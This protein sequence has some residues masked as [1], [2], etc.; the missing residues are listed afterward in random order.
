MRFDS[1]V[2][3][4]D[5]FFLAL[6]E[7]A[8]DAM[9]IV[10]TAGTIVLVNAQTEQ[11]FGY[12]RGE[13]LGQPIEMLLPQRFRAE[14]PNFR[15]TCVADPH[16]RQSKTG[17]N[18]YGLRKHGE[19]FAIEI[20][21]S[22]LE[23][24]REMFVNN[25]IR[26]V[27]ERKQVERTP[28]DQTLE[29]EQARQAK[30][31]TA[32]LERELFE[33]TQAASALRHERDR[34]LQYLDTAAGILLA[35][36]LDGRI[37]LINRKGCAILGWTEGELHG[38]NWIEMCLPT[39][40]QDA[41]RIG[42]QNQLHGDDTAIES[43]VLTR[44]G[45]ER[46]IEWRNTTLRDD[47]GQVIGTFSSG[48]DITERRQ[49]E[50]AHQRSE[51][52]YRALF[53]YAPDGIV[54]ADRESYYIDANASMCRMLGYSREEFIGLHASDIV[55]P[56]E[57]PQI[58][59]ALHTITTTADYHREWQ[60]RRK[61][62]SM[63]AADVIST[64]LPDGN[65]LAMIRDVTERNQSVDAVR[66]AEERMRFALQH[67]N[68]GIWDMDYATGVLRWS[69]TI[70]V[71]YCVPPG[72]FAGTFEAFVARI[73][74]DDRASMLDTVGAA[75][76]TGRDFTVEH[77][78][79]C[80]D[81]SVRWVSGA[82]RTLLGPHGE[83]VRGVGITQDITERKLAE[84]ILRQSEAR[85]AAILDSVLD[86]IVTMDVNGN[87]IEFNAAAERTFGYSKEAAMGRNLAE[88]IIPPSCRE[89]HSAGLARYLATGEGPLLGTLI[90]VTAIRS[91]GA[92]VPVELAIS[93]IRS[94][95]APM[96]TGVL[97]DISAR[98]H[99]DETRARL[100]AIVD[101]SDDAIFSMAVDGTI[102]TW[103][104]GAER[105]Y[106]YTADDAIGRNR[107]LLVPAGKSGEL[108]PIMDRVGRGEAGELLETQRQRKDGSIVEISLTISP[109]TD[110]TGQVTGVCTI[111]RD[112]TNRKRAEIELAHL[113]DEIQRQRLR[114]FKA[115]MRT[116]QDIVNNLL[117]NLQLAHLEGESQG[118]GDIQI[119]VERV[120]QETA[121]KLKTLG[122]LE[123]VREKEMAVGLGIDYPGAP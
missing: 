56:S 43:P 116:V 51:R 19:E 53:E 2:A 73:H 110:R 108:L 69:E 54:I 46:I 3:S 117:N 63:F 111:A 9:V 62:G 106:G 67:A 103:N 7:S 27:T 64:V 109:M 104:A 91:D 81:G 31:R 84:A 25:S 36:D 32:A 97:R 24:D 79:I 112:I 15:R 114:V 29:L 4:R 89:A 22:L 39:R 34:A 99:A 77:R 42:L 23:T 93:A 16:G 57:I 38:R 86:C 85:K 59:A 119:L 121:V 80:P 95:Q 14:Y 18:L 48:A 100:A 71:H 76:K 10:D 33:H 88:L 20:R 28:V 78:T 92:E 49:A 94:D 113:N 26:D 123:T 52:R 105:L 21:V 101:S 58:G 122:N 61:D 87:V 6:L 82:G 13:L 68:V 70:E 102:L 11:T 17:L 66:T 30:E 41:Q 60:F 98:R 45:A 72:T 12:R 55:A 75:M 115:T 96:F 44:S 74:P 37:T 8:P 107:A 1:A 47:V 120:I 90:E 118:S 5:Q 83:P 65:L 35:L 40:I 50:A